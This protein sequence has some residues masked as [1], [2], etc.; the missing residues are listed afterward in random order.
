MTDEEAGLTVEE[1]H[2]TR[3]LGSQTNGWLDGGEGWL[4]RKGDWL[5]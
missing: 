1:A 3:I 4:D 2:L 5:T